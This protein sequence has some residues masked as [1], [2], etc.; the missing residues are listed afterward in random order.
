MASVLGGFVLYTDGL[1][2]PSHLH[3]QVYRRYYPAILIILQII[4]PRVIVAHA[5]P[6]YSSSS[7]DPHPYHHAY[8]HPCRHHHFPMINTRIFIITSLRSLSMF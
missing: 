1:C 2:S 5:P 4:V 3:S 8:P 6:P 7:F